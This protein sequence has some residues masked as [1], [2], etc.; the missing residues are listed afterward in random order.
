MGGREA[1]MDS[2]AN[3]WDKVPATALSRALA[4]VLGTTM[5][6]ALNRPIVA[7]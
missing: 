4:F 2:H 3:R 1:A 7:P 6:M 5:T